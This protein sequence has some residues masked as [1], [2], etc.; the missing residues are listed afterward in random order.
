ME[1]CINCY[2]K[3]KKYGFFCSKKC[4]TEF[5]KQYPEDFKLI[6]KKKKRTIIDI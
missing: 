4:E 5:N 2:L 3:E 1:K 6:I